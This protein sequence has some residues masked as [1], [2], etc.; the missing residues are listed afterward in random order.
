VSGVQYGII[1]AVMPPGGW[2]YPQQL[3]TGETVNLK[4][5]SFEQILEEILTFRRRHMD[6]C[7]AENSTIQ[8]V[9]QD[10][11]DYLCSHFRQ[12]CADSPGAAPYSAIGAKPAYKPPIDRAGDWLAKIGNTHTEKVDYALAG[13]R[14]EICVQCPHNVKWKTGCQS[15]N[16]NV[17]IRIQNI[18]GSLYTPYDK[19]LLSCRSYGWVNAVAVWIHN[20][21]AEAEH[22]PPAHCW[23]QQHG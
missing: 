6:L 9:R 21:T 22:A 20:P 18:N 14:A 10:L 13:G 4:A 5:F 17:A 11:K 15:C 7:G 12:N 16:D 8:K 23:V 2:H 1:T 3:S 19:R